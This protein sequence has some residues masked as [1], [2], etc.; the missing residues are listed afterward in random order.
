MFRTKGNLKKHIQKTHEESIAIFVGKFSDQRQFEERYTK[1]KLRKNFNFFG[2]MFKCKLRGKIFQDEGNLKKHIQKTH[3][4]K[5][6]LL[7]EN[8]TDQR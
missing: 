4:E 6:Q 8:F 2:K 7:W 1:T 5:M 3:V